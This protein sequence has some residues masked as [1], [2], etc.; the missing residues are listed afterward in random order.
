M[1]AV[2]QLQTV[3]QPMP[4]FSLSIAALAQPESQDQGT[5]TSFWPLLA[6]DLFA[7]LR[8][9]EAGTEQLPAN[10]IHYAS[11]PASLMPSRL[12]Q[13]RAQLCVMYNPA[14]PMMASVNLR[15]QLGDY[16]YCFELDNWMLTDCLAA[17]YQL[18]RAQGQVLQAK[19]I[20][21]LTRLARLAGRHTAVE[22]AE[23][24][25]WYKTMLHPLAGNFPGLLR[26]QQ[27]VEAALAPSI[28]INRLS[29]LLAAVEA[30]RAFPDSWRN[31]QWPIAG[32]AYD[33]QEA[34]RAQLM[35]QL[36]QAA[37]LFAQVVAQ[38]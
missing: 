34:L 32:L 8:L 6:N 9:T 16:F 25:D 27:Q 11:L 38:D 28:G 3:A 19:A 2:P 23:V 17:S 22:E 1:A 31:R 35:N 10:T 36:P 7:A 5:Q 4:G 24:K 33:F 20:D 21:F 13:G 15:L 29:A 12:A 18:F 30:A 37:P 26:K 14:W